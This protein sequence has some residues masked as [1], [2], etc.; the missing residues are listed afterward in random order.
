[1]SGML[2]DVRYALRG[3]LKSPGF[4]FVAVFSLALGIGA[5]TAIFTLLDQVLLRRLP[6]KDPEQLALLTMKGSHYG[7]NWGGNAISYP[8][9]Q[10][11]SQNNQ[12]FSGMFC[13]FPTS[14]S[15]TLR[16]GD[17]AGGRGA[18]VRNLFPRAR[19]TGRPRPHLHG[20]GG[21]DP[22]AAIPSWSL[23]HAYWKRALRRAT[24]RWWA[25]TVQS[26]TA[27]TD[28]RRAW[29]SPAST[30]WSSS[31]CPRSSCP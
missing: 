13:R 14:V 27:T 2:Q 18:R 16:G 3:L 30:A 31:S 8:L 25:E 29:P 7:S 15:L 24:P 9:Y 1:M 20:R 4:T 19:G 21:S 26:S 22:A 23:S 17:G 5:N 12:V 11:L 28:G 6:V 10:D